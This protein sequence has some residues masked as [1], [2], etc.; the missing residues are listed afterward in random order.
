[1]TKIAILCLQAAVSPVLAGWMMSDYGIGLSLIVMAAWILTIFTPSLCRAYIKHRWLR[2][3]LLLL[4]RYTKL[5][6]CWMSLGVLLEEHLATSLMGYFL[7]I[8]QF[9][10]SGWQNAMTLVGYVFISGA[11]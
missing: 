5:I 8:G 6:G 1:M 7:T 10:F 11:P 2:C 3:S 4:H 9:A